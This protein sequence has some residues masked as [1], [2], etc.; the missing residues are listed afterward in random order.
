MEDR[1]GILGLGYG[2]HDVR[3]EAAEGTVPI[4]GLYTYDSRSNRENERQIAGQ[5]APG[6]TIAITPAFRVRPVV[7]VSGGLTWDLKEVTPQAVKF[8][9]TGAGSYTLIGE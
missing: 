6:D 7:L 3:V 8:G 2:L 9:G 1:R 5:A 4:L